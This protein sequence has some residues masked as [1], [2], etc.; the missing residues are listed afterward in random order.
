MPTGSW[1]RI[2]A[3]I[4]AVGVFCVACSGSNRTVSLEVYTW[5]KEDSEKRAFES[6]TN[7]FATGH[8]DA[9]V[10]NVDA[11]SAGIT[12]KELP[13]RMLA[14]N[15]PASFQANIGAD[16]LHWTMVDSTTADDGFNRL[17]DLP[18]VFAA[19]GLNA[20][21]YT[22]L[23]APLMV[24][25]RGPFAVPLNV[26]RL[27]VIYYNK[28]RMASKLP[29]AV[30]GP[31]WADL[32]PDDPSVLD[33]RAPFTTFFA[34][35]DN[36]WAVTLLVFEAL[37]PALY[38]PDFYQEIFS[39]EQ[40]D[41]WTMKVRHVLSCLAYLAR[42]TDNVHREVTYKWSDGAAS[43]A[44][45]NG[46]DLLVMGDWVRGKLREQLGAT[47]DEKI[48]QGPEG[49]QRVF[50]FTSDTFPLP[51]GTRHPQE[52]REW[53][54]TL[55]DPYVQYLFSNVKGSMPARRDAP[56]PDL[57]SAQTIADAN[58]PDVIKL[59]ATSGLFPPYYDG[60]GVGNAL[61]GIVQSPNDPELIE[62][63]IK[64]IAAQSDLLKDWRASLATRVLRP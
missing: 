48:L 5:W 58:N 53:L 59:L 1:M 8:D 16:L 21:L 44:D 15:P 2:R 32:C 19:N 13:Q 61:L 4:A 60:A 22:F 20:N 3:A 38:G 63:A 52:T 7:Y 6:V 25:T 47:V 14:G 57:S 36:A 45:P 49:V 11:D 26:H 34:D 33:G 17:A 29:A 43:V 9:V 42:P 41:G 18:D 31:T 62:D 46:A 50:V 30:N 39:G 10:S 64:L 35:A 37:V 24:G 51:L 27:N 40:P 28:Q 23:R 55:A 56:A 12:R 54:E